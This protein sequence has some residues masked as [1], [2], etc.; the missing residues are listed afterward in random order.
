MI[1]EIE[2][3]TKVYESK[4]RVVALDGIDLELKQGEIF[5]LLARRDGDAGSGLG[6]AI[7]KTFIEAHG[8]SIWVEDGPEGGARF[9]FTPPMAASIPEEVRIGADPHN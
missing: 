8:Q 6:L 3:L 7:A 4:L 9:C 2:A 1:V 5:G